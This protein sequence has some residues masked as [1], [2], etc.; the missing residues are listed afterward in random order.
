MKPH[1]E[2]VK[3]HSVAL[4]TEV[5]LLGQEKHTL[6]QRKLT[7]GYVEAYTNKSWRLTMEL[8]RLTLEL[9]KNT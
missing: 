7:Y 6:E 9:I 3:A 2:E 1:P 4:D 8:R 5:A